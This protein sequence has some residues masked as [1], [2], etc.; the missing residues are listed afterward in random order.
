[1]TLDSP[2]PGRVTLTG[3][4]TYIGTVQIEIDDTL[5]ETV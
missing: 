1:V 5:G 3:P 2:A 4:A